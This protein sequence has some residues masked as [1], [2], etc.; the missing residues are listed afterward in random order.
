MSTDGTHPPSPLIG[1]RIAFIGGGNMASALIG[2]L[3]RAGCRAADL[4]VVDPGADARQRLRERYGV[5]ALA[6]ADPTL[7]DC[8]LA[9][10]AVK[11]Q[12]FRDAAAAAAP[13][14]GEALHVSVAAGIRC[15]SMRAWFGSRRIVRTMPNTP[16]LVGQGMTGVYALP[17]VSTGDRKLTEALIAVTGRWV[18]VDDEAALD[19]VTALSGSGPAYVFY[20]LEAMREAGMQMGLSPAVALELAIGTFVGAAHLAQDAG[21]PPEVLRERVTSKGGTTAA[22]LAVL[23]AADVKG[24]FIDALHAARHRAQELGDA[25]GA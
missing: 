11:P 14:L 25:F 23:E 16:A 20:F 5:A 7:A 8:G 4:V 10:W 18:W 15:A 9:V 13:H 24:R 21:E 2:G 12:T 1:Q 6:A 3:L 19:A 22:A 17:G